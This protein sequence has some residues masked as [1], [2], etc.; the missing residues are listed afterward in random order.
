MAIPAAAAAQE[1]SLP[2]LA[3]SIE[4]VLTHG[5]WTAAGASG[6]YRVIVLTEGWESVR[7]RVIV[8]W[9]EE[10]QDA[11]ETVVRATVDL[12]TILTDAYSVSAP[13]ITKRGTAWQLT[14]RTSDRPLAQAT[15]PVVFT[16]GPPG[17]IRRA[18]VR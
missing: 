7:R 9:L 4:T 6:A 11:Q 3:P 16:L 10:D 1:D 12:G 2:P 17:I 8:Q 15:T 18:R 5:H 13:V 14:V